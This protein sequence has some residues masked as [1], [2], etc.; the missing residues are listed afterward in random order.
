MSGL[1][2]D[3]STHV[4]T[5]PVQSWLTHAVPWHRAVAMRL[6]AVAALLGSLTAGCTGNGF[7]PATDRFRELPRICDLVS[8]ATASR[9]IGVGYKRDAIAVETTGYCLWTYRDLGSEGARPFERALSLHVSLHRSMTR[10]SGADGALEELGRLSKDA[11]GQFAPAPGVGEH[12]VRSTSGGSI[13]YIIVVDNLNLKMTFS[14]RDMDAEGK[15]VAIPGKQAV[16][17]SF[18]VAREIVH[19]LELG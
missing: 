3:Q 10:R 8:P 2:R 19:N 17:S 6:V 13:N 11:S 15:L 4:T 18:E 1:L 14:G 5:Y 9:V 7:A 16:S 12:A